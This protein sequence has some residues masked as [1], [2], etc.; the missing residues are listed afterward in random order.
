VIAAFDIVPV[1]LVAGLTAFVV[2][3]A[4]M[5]FEN[6]SAR[7]TKR[8]AGTGV[9][10]RVEQE[11]QHP[12]Q[13]LSPSAA[14]L[15]DKARSNAASAVRSAAGPQSTPEPAQPGTSH[16]RREESVDDRSTPA[17][18]QQLISENLTPAEA[19][20]FATFVADNDP[21]R[22]AHVLRE[23]LTHD[24]SRT[25]FTAPVIPDTKPRKEM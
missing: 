15:L 11:R 1:L 6:F 8:P 19:A 14:A 21:E 16:L 2:S 7:R 10:D 5:L 20:D 4:A 23:W 3:T 22:V 13:E 12:E 9:S 18:L 17:T 25:P 24:D